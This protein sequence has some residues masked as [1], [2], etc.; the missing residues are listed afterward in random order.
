MDARSPSDSLGRDVSGMTGLTRGR[1]SYSWQTHG[2]TTQRAFRPAARGSRAGA[3]DWLGDS[4]NA[5]WLGGS[6]KQGFICDDGGNF[7]DPEQSATAFPNP[8]EEYLPLTAVCTQAGK[9]GRA[10]TSTGFVPSP[11]GMDFITSQFLRRFNSRT[12]FIDGRVFLHGWD[13]TRA[14]RLSE[15]FNQ[16]GL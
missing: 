12:P 3:R 8:Y 13:R 9:D 4:N 5:M 10:M 2:G 16:H 1:N 11:R 14:R 15:R 6:D 7:P